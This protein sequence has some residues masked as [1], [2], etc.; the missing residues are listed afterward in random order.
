MADVEDLGDNKIFGVPTA[1]TDV[2]VYFANNSGKTS[3]DDTETEK[4]FDFQTKVKKFQI[5]NDQTVLLTAVN[6]RVFTNPET[7][8]LNKG[9]I[10][11]FDTA[12]V[13]KI[14]IRTLTD[15]TTLEIRGI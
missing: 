10:E 2:T 12:F 11:R 13:T 6:T 3:A 15:N 5:R 1:G 9:I 8:T 14:T 4:Y 7:A